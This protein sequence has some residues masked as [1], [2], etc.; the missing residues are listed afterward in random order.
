MKEKTFTDIRYQK[1]DGTGIVTVTLNRPERRNA[2][3]H[4]SF[5]ELF[6][7]AEQVEKDDSAYAMI[8][9]GAA[10]PD[11]SDPTREAFSSGGNFDPSVY[12]KLSAD[13]KAEIDMADVAQKRLTLK[14][15]E[16]DKP[17]IAAINGL[18]I[19]GGLTMCMACA[20]LVYASEYAWAELPFNRLGLIPELASTYILPRLLGFQKAKEVLFFEGR[21][22]A[23]R[24]LELG[25]INGVIPHTELMPYVRE[26]AL[27]LIPPKGAWQAVRLAKRAIHE[28]LIESLKK[29]LDAENAGFGRALATADF[30][31]GIMA[32]K[33]KRPPVFT[34]H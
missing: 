25:L 28:P 16:L 19:G 17:V 6:W 18:A 34:G 9:T 3:D 7:A 30:V 15:W 23:Q 21:M 12:E 8:I 13:I 1:D 32:R 29:A 26:R 11:A 33:Q 10:G 5:L 31:E 24:L 22:S 4:Y 2:L 27:Q 20:D 14:M